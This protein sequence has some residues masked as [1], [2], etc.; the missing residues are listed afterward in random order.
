M[1]QTKFVL[2]K[3]LKLGLKPIVAIN[4]I[5]KPESRPDAVL[6][7]VFDLFAGARCQ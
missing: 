7:E 3:A 1:P 4:K 6:D 5:D 2:S